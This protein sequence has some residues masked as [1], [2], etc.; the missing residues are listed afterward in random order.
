[1][2]PWPI[3]A[4]GEGTAL[5]RLGRDGVRSLLSR[6]AAFASPASYEPF[7]LGIVEAA[8]SGCALVVAGI[9]SLLEVWGDAALFVR[10]DDDAALG[11]AL[12][13]VACDEELRVELAERARRRS[14]RYS[15]ERMAAGYAG[16]YERVLARVPA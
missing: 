16:V 13:L 11:A 2:T 5:G 8:R 7:G 15:V 4:A 6:A 14:V 12:R 1:V 9:P 10:P 3:V